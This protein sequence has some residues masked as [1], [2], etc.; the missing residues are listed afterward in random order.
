MLATLFPADA[1][2][3]LL[4]FVRIGGALMLIPG[5]GEIYVSP[6]VRLGLAV[7]L[8][9]IV[10]PLVLQVLPPLPATPLEMLLIVAGETF[11][12]I[13][14]G[15]SARMILS[16][17]H[18]AGTVIAFQS[19]L[20]YA[21]TVDPTQGTQ[22]ALVATLMTLIGLV[23]IFAANLH[24][25][26]LLSLVDSYELFRPGALP[27]LDTFMESAVRFVGNSFALGLQMSAPFIVYGIVLYMG[28]GLLARLMP[29]MNVFFIVLP[30]Q[31]AAAFLVFII[32]LSGTMIWFLDHFEDAIREFTVAGVGG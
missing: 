1:F 6:R 23:M 8:T 30:L 4:V 12:G 14:I 25:I 21:M 18:I 3:T 24:H 20:A 22:S 32:S 17:L 31:I 26:L 10:T 9:M 5:F 11:V 27:P 29:Q 16:A 28:L 19:S 13:M 15:A 2:S 7:A